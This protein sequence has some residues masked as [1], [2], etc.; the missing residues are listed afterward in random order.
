V[1]GVP[2]LLVDAVLF[3]LDGTLVDESA[4]YRE[5]IRLT[6]EYLLRESVTPDEVADIKKVPGFN[7]DWDATWGLVARRLGSRAIVPDRA[8]RESQA[9]RR[10]QN[11]FQTYYLGDRL[12]HEMSGAEPPFAW[13]EPLIAKETPHVDPETLHRLSGF[14]LGIVTSRPRAEA[15]MAVHQHD[16]D[17]FFDADAIVAAGDAPFEKPD[18]AP[19]RELVRR[20]ECRSPVYVGDTINDALAAFAAGMPFLQVGLE[21]FGDPA[22]DEKVHVRVTSVDEIL[23]VFTPAHGAVGIVEKT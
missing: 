22:V 18:P 9:F 11:A 2:A 3:D 23:D 6:A 14:A 19:L 21:G 10:L 7:N 16:F 13:S 15:L 17:R 4:S 20:L 1:S 8:D 5:A 12:W